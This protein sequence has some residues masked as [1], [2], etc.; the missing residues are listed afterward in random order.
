MLASLRDTVTDL[1]N[2]HFRFDNRKQKKQYSFKQNT[3]KKH[4][5]TPTVYKRTVCL[6]N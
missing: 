5:D 2:P 3:G 6:D 1:K 4:I